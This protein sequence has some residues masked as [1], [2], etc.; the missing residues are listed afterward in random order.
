MYTEFY[1]IDV[2]CIGTVSIDLYYKGESLTHNKD[3]FELA[4][5]GK[6]FADH[7]YE[8]L[9]GG[10]ANVAIGIIKNGLTAGLVAK[11]GNNPFKKLIIE[12]LDKEK[13]HYN[14]FCQFEDSYTNISSILLNEKG[15]KTI[16]NYR[17]PHQKVV[18]CEDDYNRLTKAK[19]IY[20]ANLSRVAFDE[21]ISILKFAKEKGIKTFVNLNVTDCRRP[22]EQ[23]LHMLR[24][25]DVLIINSH[26]FADMV[27]TSFSSIDFHHDV[28]KKYAPFI[29]TSTQVV[30]T[31]GAR[32]SYA[33]SD[34][35]V[36]YD[37]AISQ[38]KVVDTTGAGDGYT[39][40]FIAE[41]LKSN[42]NIESSMKR[43]SEY[44]A[45]MLGK[46]GAN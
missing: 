28:T 9:G 20:M 7:F 22:I 39:A 40:A 45:K 12:K 17:T 35:K 27:K 21:R 4:I 1:M 2:L 31:D 34:N 44:A 18:N 13:V 33:Y 32:G 46:I 11:I 23:I 5:G 3:R 29:S 6:Y 26:E 15:E 19:A 36:F 10:G 16:I 41:Y 43:G 8:G 25:V 30:V 42:G 37:T 24:H 14:D 38:V